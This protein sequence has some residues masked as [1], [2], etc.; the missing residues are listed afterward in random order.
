[1]R[2]LKSLLKRGALV[3][4]A[5]WQ[6]TLVQSTADTLFKLLIAAPIV[7]GLV[8]A[9]LVL[10]AEPRQLMSLEWRDMGIAIASSL[11][12]HPIVLT[13]FLLAVGVVGVGGSLFIFLVKGGTVATLVAGERDAGPIEQPPL[14]VEMLVRAG[15]FSVD[16]FIES[17]RRL[18]PRYARLGLVLMGIYTA[19]GAG[20]LMVVFAIGL[21]GDRWGSAALSPPASWSGSRSSTCCT[22]SSRS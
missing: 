2:G 17:S 9:V 12:S 15:R 21:L 13:A 20:Y 6:V 10:G 22:S 18:F 16:L 11:L 19:S 14:H 1:M 5:N 7:G 8:L 3:A 4:A